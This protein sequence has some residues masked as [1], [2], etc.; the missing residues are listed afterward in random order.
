MHLFPS[1]YC[2]FLSKCSGKVVRH[3]CVVKRFSRCVAVLF[4]FEK[5][6][7]HISQGR[8]VQFD[9]FVQFDCNINSVFK[10][11]FKSVINNRFK[12]DVLDCVLN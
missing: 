6:R 3:L 5:K 11:V 9:I 8:S 7:L 1:K 2:K 12:M 10:F 4:W